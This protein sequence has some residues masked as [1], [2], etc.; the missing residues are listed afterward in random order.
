MC[1]SDDR[2]ADDVHYVGG[3]VLASTCSRGRR[4]CSRCYALPPDPAAVGDGWR[5]MWLERLERTPPFVEAWLAHQRRDDYWRQGSVCEDY[6]AIEAPVYAVGGWADGY[7]NAVPRL[8]EGLPGPRKGLIGPW[9]H[10]FPQDG[11]PGPGDRLPAGVPALVRPP[12]QGHRHG[13]SWTSRSCAL[14]M[15]EPVAPAD[16]HAQRPG[17]WVAEPAW[18]PPSIADDA[19][20]W[21]FGPEQPIAHRSLESAGIDAGAWCAD[22]G[23]GDWPGD[24]R[25]EDGRSLSFTLAAARRATSR[26]SASRRSTL[27]ARGRPPRARSSPSACARSRPTASRCSSRAACSTSPTATATRAASRWTPAAATTSRVRL[28]AIAQRVP[29]GHRL[30]VAVSTAYWPW[31]WPVAGAGHAHAARGRAARCPAR[32]PRDEQPRRFGCAG[33]GRA[34]RG[35]DDRARPHD[36]ARTTT[37]RPPARTSCASSGT[38]AATAGSSTAASRCTTPTSPPTASSTAT[39]CRPACACSAARRSAAATGARACTPTAR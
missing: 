11:E 20:T 4:R 12:A 8:I 14:W 38:S 27:G 5:D 6:A 2:Y 26:S 34:A 1:A 7:S 31:A 36:R 29:A 17:R 24:Q 23:Q 33:V 28:D 25:A 32:P 18:P 16:H 35:R 3:C 15:Q 13:R 19:S 37:T 10:A 22:G 39:R 30:R 9:S 21:D